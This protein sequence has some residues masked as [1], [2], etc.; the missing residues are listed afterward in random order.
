[1]AIA[2]DAGP[3]LG[4]LPAAV[5]LEVFFDFLLDG[6]LKHLAGAFGDELF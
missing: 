1:M 6:G 4:A 5:G 2:H 3:A